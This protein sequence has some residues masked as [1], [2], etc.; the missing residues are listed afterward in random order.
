MLTI[1]HPDG[2]KCF[3]KE[4]HGTRKAHVSQIFVC[5][6]EH[7]EDEDKLTVTAADLC[8]SFPDV[9]H[10]LGSEAVLVCQGHS[11]WTVY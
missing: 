8:P 11:Q 9:F 3:K 5:N 6:L 4:K 2:F 7:L 1:Q 10:L